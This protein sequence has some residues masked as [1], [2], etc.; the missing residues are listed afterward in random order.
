MSFKNTGFFLFFIIFSAFSC[1]HFVVRA[2]KTGKPQQNAGIGIIIK[3]KVFSRSIAEFM[4]AG[5]SGAGLRPKTINPDELLPPEIRDSI[6]PDYRYSFLESLIMSMYGSDGAVK[7]N[8]D[9]LMQMLAVNNLTESNMRLEELAK[10]INQ[11]RDKWEI[12]YIMTI[13][14]RNKLCYTVRVT[15]LKTKSLIFIYYIDANKRGWKEK[16]TIPPESIG[17]SVSSAR[18]GSREYLEIQFCEYIA[19]LLK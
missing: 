2:A 10:L 3:G 18:K 8:R 17:L 1:K 13:E 12:E 7:G 15:E 11:F 5:L 16:I 4:C 19:G 6:N 14:Q 9:V